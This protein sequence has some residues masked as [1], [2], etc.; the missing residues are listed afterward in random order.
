MATNNT[1]RDKPAT[2]NQLMA[3]LMHHLQTLVFQ[4]RQDIRGTDDD[5]HDRRGN[6]HYLVATWRLLSVFK[7][8]RRHVG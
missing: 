4:P 3:Y 8:Y 5:D 1:R 6:R 7:K 2:S